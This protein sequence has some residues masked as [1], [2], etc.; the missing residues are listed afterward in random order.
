[1]DSAPKNSIERVW[2][3]FT[4]AERRVVAL[5]RQVW[6]TSDEAALYLRLPTAKALYQTV[7]RG[8]LPVHYLGNRLR[9]LRTE[10][11]EAL[12]RSRE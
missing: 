9:F 4:S 12:E 8:R 7:R 6:L 11:D 3:L 1:M 5:G 2:H 10:L